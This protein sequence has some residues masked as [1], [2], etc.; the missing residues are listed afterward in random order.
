VDATDIIAAIAL[1]VSVAAAV[2]AVCFRESSRGDGEEIRLLR[3]EVDRLDEEL[4]L[5]FR[6]SSRRDGE[7]IRLLRD[8]EIRL[9]RDE[10]GRL[11]EE[12]SL[13]RQQV[14]YE[15]EERELAERASVTI[16]AAGGAQSSPG[17]I[18]FEFRV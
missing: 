9:L 11:D 8:E 2:A 4:S 13:I 1:A 14:E 5:S 7:E 10:A 17:R 16:V 18:R 3:D 6:E 15:R 12:L